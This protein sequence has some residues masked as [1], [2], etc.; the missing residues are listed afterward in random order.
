MS[1]GDLLFSERSQKGLDQRERGQEA[2][3]GRGEVGETS[4]GT[5]YI[6]E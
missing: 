3:M 6:T 5:K 2:D 1:L 4:V